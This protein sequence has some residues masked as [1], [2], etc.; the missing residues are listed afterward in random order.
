MGSVW[1]PEIA[2]L[3][4]LSKGST[5][6]SLAV[7][8]VVA[9]TAF[10]FAAKMIEGRPFKLL[11]AALML[12]MG[13]SAVFAIIVGQSDLTSAWTFG[14]GYVVFVFFFALTWPVMYATTPMSFPT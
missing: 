9:M 7:A 6:V 10:L 11:T 13:A 8:R 1:V 5:Y 2:Q 12:T 14:A 4:H 3:R